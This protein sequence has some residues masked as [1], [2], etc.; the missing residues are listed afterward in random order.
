MAEGEATQ[1]N[2][3]DTWVRQFK[4]NVAADPTAHGAWEEIKR[5]GIEEGALFLLYGYAG[6]ASKDISQM[7]RRSE[8]ASRRMKAAIRGEEVAQ[9]CKPIRAHDPALFSKRAEEAHESAFRADWP[10]PNPAARVQTVADELALAS[11]LKGKEVPLE[12]ARKAMVKAAGERSPVNPFCFLFLLQGYAAKYG[13]TL[14]NK[15]L[16]TLAWCALPERELD[17]GT[18]GRYLRDIPEPVREGVLRDSLPTLPAPGQKTK[19]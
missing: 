13:V 12:D 17:E 19:R 15:R 10:M 7:H 8:S 11:E 14:G 3:P 6:G 5:G 4:Q 2:I 1:T 18:L 9:T 16:L